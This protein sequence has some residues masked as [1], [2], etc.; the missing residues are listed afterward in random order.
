MKRDRL[1]ITKEIDGYKIKGWYQPCWA[2]TPFVQGNTSEFAAA[3][4]VT[5]SG[6]DITELLI[7]ENSNPT[8]YYWEI[9]AMLDSN[10]ITR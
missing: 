10:Y 2:G 3:K 8:S 5:S 4:V 6:R 1:W 9:L 7:D